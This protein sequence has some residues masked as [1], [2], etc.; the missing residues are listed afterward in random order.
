MIFDNFE[1]KEK[2]GKLRVTITLDYDVIPELKKLKKKKVNVSGLIN[3]F[4][5]YYINKTKGGKK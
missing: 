3:Q 1:E 4:L 2:R 5:W